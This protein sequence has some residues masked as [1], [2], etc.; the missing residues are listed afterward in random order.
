VISEDNPTAWRILTDYGTVFQDLMRID[1]DFKAA[2]LRTV[3]AGITSN[4]PILSMQ[5]LSLIMDALSKTL[6]I[7]HRTVLNELTSRLPLSE[8][9]RTQDLAAP[10]EIVDDEMNEESEA[11]ASARRLRE[12]KPSELDNDIKNTGY[13]LLAQR[14]AAEI[15]TN[16]CS[17]EDSEMNE[18]MDDD[19]SGAESVNDYDA[20]EQNGH[21]IAGDKIPVEISEAVKSHVIVEKVSVK[22]LQEVCS[23]NLD[24]SHEVSKLIFTII[25]VKRYTCGTLI[26]SLHLRFP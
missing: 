26:A 17:N 4:V 10:I 12:D 5:N 8:D 21:Q 6:E 23:S 9:E 15:L 2:I 24:L 20:S 13:L 25:H 19:L 18:D 7:N 11:D 22:S 3:A 14:V 1:G 16:M